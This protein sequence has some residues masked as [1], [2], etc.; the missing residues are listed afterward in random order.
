MYLADNP[1]KIN[2]KTPANFN[3]LKRYTGG[4]CCRFHSAGVVVDTSLCYHYDVF[5]P[6]LFVVDAW[7]QLDAIEWDENWP[8]KMWE[9][10]VTEHSISGL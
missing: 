6:A 3:F 9:D 10:E 2:L 8:D 4:F 1:H 7:A 5:E